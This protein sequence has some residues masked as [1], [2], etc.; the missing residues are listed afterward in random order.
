MKYI[1]L[2][3][4]TLVV[5]CPT[6]YAATFC[7]TTSAQLQTALDDANVNNQDNLIKITEG[8]YMTPGSQ[9]S[10]NLAGSNGGWD[11]EISGGWRFAMGF[12]CN[13]QVP[14]PFATRL[15]GDTDNRVMQ[16][17]VSND[18]DLTVSNLTFQSGTELT[19][20][21]NGAGLKVGTPTLVNSLG[22]FRLERCAFNLN[23]ATFGS[24]LSVAGFNT[25]RIQ[26]NLF[27]GNH[28]T[29]ADGVVYLFQNNT[30]GI[31]FINN[32][33]ML[34]S[35]GNSDYS[36][37]VHINVLGSSN[38]AIYNNILWDNEGSDLLLSGNGKHYLSHND[39]GLRDGV[40]PFTNTENISVSPQFAGIPEFA[41][42][43]NSPLVNAGIKQ[44]TFVPIPTPFDDD[45]NVGLFDFYRGDRIQ[46]GKVDIGAVETT[47]EVPIFMDGFE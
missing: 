2:F 19:K 42:S 4:I 44:P 5:Y 10:Y 18:F 20:L 3:L 14:N 39:I 37:G 11:L 46:N 15:N 7:V 33:V 30:N 26:N 47:P 21:N 25:M 35:H 9:F 28:A 23:D 31:Y 40:A 27:V 41:L 17:V 13:F 16:I 32:T 8:S 38:A 45:W 36:A 12:A 43:Q 29:E 22:T 6:S 1:Y 24:A 34:N